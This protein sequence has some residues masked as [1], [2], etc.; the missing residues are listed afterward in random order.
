MGVDKLVNEITSYMVSDG[1]VNYI[2]LIEQV[3]IV[4]AITGTVLGLLVTL[5]VIFLPIVIVIEIL[6]LNIPVI[7]ESI[8]QKIFENGNKGNIILGLVLRDARLAVQKANTIETGKSVN[9]IYLQLKIKAILLAI[10]LVGLV[11]GVGGTIVQVIVKIAKPI[12]DAFM[13]TM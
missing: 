10:I 8:E 3:G 12:I 9:L 6:Y 1:S 13:K 2:T 5:I 4:D 11:L 7:Q